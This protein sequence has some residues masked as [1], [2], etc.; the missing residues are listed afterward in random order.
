MQLVPQLLNI[1]VAAVTFSITVI[2]STSPTRI[3]NTSAHQICIA[4]VR[5]HTHIEFAIDDERARDD[6]K[7][8]AH[9]TSRCR[10]RQQRHVECD[11]R[12]SVSDVTGHT[13]IFSRLQALVEVAN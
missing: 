12:A 7:H 5:A 9:Q 3:Y 10:A 2:A 11:L 4:R 1:T 8:A 13:T 6:A